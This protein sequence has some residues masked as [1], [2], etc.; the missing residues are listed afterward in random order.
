[1]REVRPLREDVVTEV[2]G[3]RMLSMFER[4]SRGEVLRKETEAKRFGV[5][6]KTIQRDIEDLRAYLAEAHPGDEFNNIEYDKAQRGYVLRR[7]GQVW[8][9]RE[10]VLWLARILL[11]SRSLPAREMRSLL[12][13]LV[14]Q[15]S[16]EERRRITEI[17]RNEAH[18]YIPLRHGRTLLT[19]LWEL[20]RACRERRI[21]NIEYQREAD[22]KPIERR[23]RPQAVLF[24]EYYF[25]LLAF[26]DGGMYDFPTIYRL[27]RIRSYQVTDN[28]FRIMEADRFE[29]GEFRKRIQFMQSG[30]LLRVTFKFWGESLEAILDRLPTAKIIG[31]DGNATVLRAETFGRGIKMWFLSQAQFLEVLEPADFREEMRQT[32]AE[33]MKLYG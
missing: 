33:M 30:R 12:D 29:E 13:K 17:V 23:L 24:S 14:A 18:H 3:F 8:L 6:G 7:D 16:P 11:E 1:M 22:T 9:T 5:N 26:I 4:L 28:H 31:Q 15:C 19:T 32:V 10:E 2:K 27:D 21:V 20:S 25:Y